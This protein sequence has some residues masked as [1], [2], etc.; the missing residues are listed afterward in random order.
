MGMIMEL[1]PATPR[2]DRPQVEDHAFELSNVKA[3]GILAGNRFWNMVTQM[4]RPKFRDI[5][6]DDLK[7]RG[8]ASCGVDVGKGAASLGCLAPTGRTELYLRKREGR[9]D[10]LRVRVSDGELD[11]DLGITDLRIYG[12]DRFTPDANVIE[13]TARR[14]AAENDVVLSVGLTRPFSASDEFPPL[15]WL[16]VNNIHFKDDAVWQL[17]VPAKVSS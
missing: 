8:R 1:G 9:P 4:A 15:H 16:Q 2:P 17:A 14:L 5:F 6:G 7:M 11:L 10:Q 13:N 12:D 3:L